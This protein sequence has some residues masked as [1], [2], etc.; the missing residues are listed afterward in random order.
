MDS[1]S[2]GTFILDKLAK[3]VETSG[4]KTSVTIKTINGESS[5]NLMAIEDLQTSNINNVE[6]G[7]IDLPKTYKKPDLPV[8]NA[9]ITQTSHLKH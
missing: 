2:Q 1:S 6:G 4:R 5:S 8:D 7:W 3:A 9:D